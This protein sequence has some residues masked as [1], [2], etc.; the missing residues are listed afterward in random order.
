MQFI[1]I[2]SSNSIMASR[3]GHTLNYLFTEL[4]DCDCYISALVT[5]SSRQHNL[6]VYATIPAF[7]HFNKQLT[8]KK[9]KRYNNL[10]RLMKKHPH[11]TATLQQTV[12]K[13]FVAWNLQPRFNCDKSYSPNKSTMKQKPRKPS[14]NEKTLATIINNP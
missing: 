13:I 9:L 11:S 6:S 4:L 1:C 10:R 14:V 7:E 8:G 12:Q 3:V 5:K 2:L